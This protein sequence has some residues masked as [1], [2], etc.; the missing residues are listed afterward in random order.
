MIQLVTSERGIG[1]F[2]FPAYNG[3]A[4]AVLLEGQP[5]MRRHVLDYPGAVMHPIGACGLGEFAGILQSKLNNDHN[6]DMSSARM[7]VEGEVKA[8]IYVHATPA[9]YIA[10]AQLAPFWDS[11]NGAYLKEVSYQTGITLLQDW[12]AKEASTLYSQASGNG[13]WVEIQAQVQHRAGLLHYAWPGLLTADVDYYLNDQATSNSAVTTVLAAA[14]LNSAKPDF[15][16]NVTITPGGT[17][18][19]VPAGDVTIVGLDIHGNVITDTITFLADASTIGSGTKAFASITSIT[20]P[21]QDGAGATY[22]V[23]FG[24]V[25]GLGRMFGVKPC[26]VQ[27]KANATVEG[28]APTTV[29]DPNEISKNTISFNTAANNTLREAWICTN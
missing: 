4:S 7:V 23:G 28:T 26:V 25:L 19:S 9:N 20:F 29:A 3:E 6:G 2:A 16:R 12:T 13:A 24:N 5:V 11:T 1:G 17:T 18:A 10:G 14:M 27:A 21:I 22:D 8:T 15:A